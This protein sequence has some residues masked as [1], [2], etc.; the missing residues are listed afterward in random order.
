M[1]ILT[2]TLNPTIDISSDVAEVR[3][4]HKIRT[5]N[6]RRHAGGGGINAA[7]VI[8]ELGGDPKAVFLSGGATGAL[9]EDALLHLGLAF[10]AIP[11]AG[12]TRIAFMVHE[13]NTGLEYRFVPEGPDVDAADLEKVIAVVKAFRG[14]FIVASGSLPHG[15]PVDTYCRMADIARQNG[16]RF[17]LDTSGQALIET[18]ARA[19]VYMVKPSRGE[20]EKFLGHTLEEATIGPAAH[21]LVE[22]GRAEVV[23]VTMGGDG[24]ILASRDGIFHLPARKLEVRSAVGAGDSFVGAFVWALAKGYSE[25]DAFR[26][27]TAAGTAAVLTPGTELC[28]RADIERIFAETPEPDR[29]KG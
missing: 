22:E 20:L 21:R 27:A 2:V 4:T 6:Q 7:R 28:K 15:A 3:P 8:A 29:I 23:C 16:M 17:V 11:I 5:Y 9:L 1:T 25:R 10:E 18:L 14:E 26:M 19:S 12:F 24:A 13:E